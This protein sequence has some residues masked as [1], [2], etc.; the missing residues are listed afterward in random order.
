MATL[1]RAVDC[2][3]NFHRY[4]RRLRNHPQRAPDWQLKRERNA[5]I[6]VATKARRRLPA[7]TLEGYPSARR[8]Y[9]AVC[10]PLDRDF[11]A[12]SCAIPGG[13]R[14]EQV[15]DNC[16]ASACLRFRRRLWKP[17]SGSTVRRSPR[18]YITGGNS[19]ESSFLEVPIDDPVDHFRHIDRTFAVLHHSAELG[20]TLFPSCRRPRRYSRY[21]T[22][23]TRNP[24]L[25]ALA[26]ELER[27]PEPCCP[28]RMH[29]SR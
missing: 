18:T 24:A 10:S 3:L 11:D 29:S 25:A 16:R 7:Q 27:R 6:V 13:K 2:G 23:R 4:R 8:D 22:S 21:R 14:P 20:Y 19:L 1:N 17:S 5:E 28:D 26:L 9:G 15:E 12:V